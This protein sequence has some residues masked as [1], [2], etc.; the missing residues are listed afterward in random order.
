[1]KT[2]NLIFVIALCFMAVSRVSGTYYIVKTF[3]N[4]GKASTEGKEGN[5]NEQG[6][7]RVECFAGLVGSKI[8]KPDHVY[9]K[10]DGTDKNGNIKVNSR[11]ITAE[12]IAAKLGVQSSA[13]DQLNNVL[14]TVQTA[15]V[16]NAVFV[17]SDQEKTKEIATSLGGTDSPAEFKKENYGSIWVI[18][19]GNNKVNEIT[20]GCEGLPDSHDNGSSSSDSTTIRVS[21]MSAVV[22]LMAS[23]Y[24]FF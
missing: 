15:N 9:Y 16:Q 3:E 12:A 20:M 8:N 2:L 19:P 18:E 23:L 17:W 10:A 22:A 7:K 21:I 4:Y 1:M 6:Q 24:L 13:I 5:L 14:E 11:K